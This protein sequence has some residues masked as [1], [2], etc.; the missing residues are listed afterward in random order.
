M[1]PWKELDIS[2]EGKAFS[3]TANYTTTFQIDG[4]VQPGTTVTLDLG[5]VD[6]I[7][8]VNVN[9]HKAGVL[10]CSPY[11]LEIG[12]FVR[13]GKNVLSID[14]TSTWY[15][16]LVFDAKQPEKERKTWTINGPSGDSPLSDSGLI[17]PVS[18]KY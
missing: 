3:G 4:E 12:D 13:T 14:V 6:M 10:W 7:A 11:T 5:R 8:D 18:I 15:N 17:G 1:K 16:R 2:D 9:G